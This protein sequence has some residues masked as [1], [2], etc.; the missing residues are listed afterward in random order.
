MTV[1]YVQATIEECAKTINQTFF[2]SCGVRNLIQSSLSL[3]SLLILD[4]IVLMKK[5]LSLRLLQMRVVSQADSLLS[6]VCA[7]SFASHEMSICNIEI[8][9]SSNT[10]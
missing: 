4:G 5:K 2:F 10:V 7:S 8:C 1:D 3:F 9:S 6:K